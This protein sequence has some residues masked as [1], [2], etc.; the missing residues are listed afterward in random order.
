MESVKGSADELGGRTVMVL[1]LSCV[2]LTSGC[3]EEEIESKWRDREITINGIADEWQGTRTYIEDPNIA[4]GVMNDENHLYLSLSTPV[5]SVAAQIVT[6]G[7]TVWLDPD[8]GKD[9]TFGIRCPIG[10][11]DFK[12]MG[13]AAGEPDRLKELFGQAAE[14]LEILGPAGGG[15][16]MMVNDG[17][18][19]I[20]VGV[21]HRDG[22]FGY[23]LKI[24]LT[25][26]S[27]AAYALGSGMSQ[28]VGIGFE[29]PQVDMEAIREAM[30]GDM[31]RGGGWPGGGLE[32][33]PPGGD[34]GGGMPG[35]GM[36]GGRMRG[37][38]PEPIEIWAKV[39][40]ATPGDPVD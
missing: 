4:V 28:L 31:P 37:G 5:R 12:M 3:G 23:E 17:S 14:R 38:R 25:T 16:V 1:I 40:L 6:L 26:D 21:S 7:F 22:T 10:F 11:E 29:T 20:E 27:G 36:R 9:K 13:E 8:G 24:P 15:S 2:A 32:G 39:T 30:G 34:M 33:G 35:G 19:G 18:S